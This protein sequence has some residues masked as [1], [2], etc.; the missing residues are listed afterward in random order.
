MAEIEKRRGGGAKTSRSETVT[1]RLDPKLRYLAEIGARAHRRTLS[2][3]I[4]EAVAAAITSVELTASNGV[5]AT[6]QQAT[7]VLWDVT[8]MDRMIRLAKAFPTLLTFEEQV[9][10]KMVRETLQ[11]L[12]GKDAG[13][14]DEPR[15]METARKYAW[16]LQT[17]VLKN[18]QP[19]E[20]A[21]AIQG[22]EELQ[23]ALVEASDLDQGKF[24][25]HRG[26]FSQ[27]IVEFTRAV[28]L[29]PEIAASEVKRARNPSRSF[30][31]PRPT[32]EP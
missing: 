31:S 22:E 21:R 4:E 24:E 9:L 12:Y 27:V 10:W 16:A 32:K 23:K 7:D 28:T 26:P 5:Q 18:F 13:N 3:F 8:P 6:L 30:F 20:V 1:V 14:F 15:D 11:A 19:S 25:F 17:A 2:S 29:L